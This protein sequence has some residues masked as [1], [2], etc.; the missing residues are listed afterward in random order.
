MR[1]ACF[2]LLLLLLR[3]RRLLLALLSGRSALSVRA[4]R[5]TNIVVR[6]P[7]LGHAA[8]R[9]IDVLDLSHIHH[10]H[11]RNRCRR[12]LAYLLNVGRT[13]RPAGILGQGRLLPI[14]GNRSGRRSRSRD[15]ASV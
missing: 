10:A 6:L 4:L 5:L 12:A 2:L 14:K 15:H 8:N 9:R 13:K 11:R 7:G 1:P 3:Q